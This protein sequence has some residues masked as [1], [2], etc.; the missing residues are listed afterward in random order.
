MPDVIHELYTRHGYPPMSHPLSDPAVS[1]VAARLAGLDV[2]HP[3]RARV[4]E[5]GCSSGHNLLPL[6]RRWPESRFTG[7][8]LA[9]R[10]VEEARGLAAACEISNTDFH[11]ADLRSFEPDDGP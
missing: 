11:A 1:A 2:A 4:L 10:A 7:I 3:R 6:A 9:E 5:I 8:D